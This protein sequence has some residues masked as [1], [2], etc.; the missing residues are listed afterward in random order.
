M[1]LLWYPHA[2]KEGAS[3]CSEPISSLKYLLGAS[4]EGLKARSPSGYYFEGMRPKRLQGW[5]MPTI[6]IT[7]NWSQH[8]YCDREKR[9]GT[10]FKGQ[11]FFTVYQQQFNYSTLSPLCYNYTF[12]WAH[13]QG[14]LKV[15]SI[16]WT[17]LMPTLQVW[18]K[19]LEEDSWV[20]LWGRG[21]WWSW[22]SQPKPLYDLLKHVNLNHQITHL[23]AHLE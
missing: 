19:A 22:H 12:S 16:P 8:R 23:C 20:T 6:V 11:S 7:T 15:V 1:Q 2:E 9:M 3:D 10:V 21:T 13:K 17:W 14:F 18:R 5:E 4:Q